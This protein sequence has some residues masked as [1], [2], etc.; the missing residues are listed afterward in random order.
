MLAG[1]PPGSFDHFSQLPDERLRKGSFGF[2][3]LEGRKGARTTTRDARARVVPDL[4]ERDFTA[5]ARDRL[6]VAD[7]TYI[8]TWAGFLLLA[9]VLN[10]FRRRM[11]SRSMANHLHMRLVLDALDMALRQCRPD[12]CKRLHELRERLRRRARGRAARPHEG[13]VEVW[14]LNATAFGVKTGTGFGL[15]G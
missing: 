3:V 8:V 11:V 14:S 1:K 15:L 9:V 4:V 13:P 6:W 10:A 7:V 5:D 2:S 12:I